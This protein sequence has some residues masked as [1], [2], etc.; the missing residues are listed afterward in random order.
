MKLLPAHLRASVL[1]AIAALTI[2]A[3]GDASPAIRLNQI[4]FLPDTVKRAV[5]ASDSTVPL[6][7][8]VLDEHGKTVAEGQTTVVGADRA[9]GD[10]VHLVRFDQVTKPGTYRI[11]ISDQTS[12]AF[13]VRTGL[14][15]PLASAALNFFYQNRAGIPI[16]A[17]YAGGAQWARP[18]GHP[19]EIATCFRGTDERGTV[20][21]GCSYTLDVTGGWYDAGDQG[22]YVVNG[23]ISLW[24]LQNL[25]ER[26]AASGRFTF[27]DG[28]ARLPEAGNRINDLLDEARWEMRFLLAMQIPDG[29]RAE[30]PVG[31]LPSTGPLT[32]RTI[33]AGGMAHQKVADRNWTPLPTP[34]HNDKEDRLLYP[35][36]TGATLNL[37]AVAAQCARIWRRVDPTFSATCLAAAK[38]AYRAA[39]RNP[40]VYATNS[41]TGSGGYGDND[42]SDELYWATAELWATTGEAVYGDALAA[43]PA[44]SA[45]VGEP[46]WGNVGALGTITLAT[47]PGIPQADAARARAALVAAADGFL[48]ETERSGYRI[49]YA[50]LDY[51]WGSN[52]SILNRAMILG[53]AHGLTGEARYRVGVVDAMDYM[54][55]RNPLDQSYVSGFGARPLLNPH[56]RFWAHQL[57]PSLPG[58]PPG[59]VSGGP[60]STS[61]SD[62]IALTMKG[63]CAPQRCW[64]D[65]ISAYALNEVAINWNAPLLWVAA[66]LDGGA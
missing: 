8:R 47:A 5:V 49:P 11:R 2:G 12:R 14:Y 3:A 54:L 43:M 15:A 61:M 33:D 18:A 41:F 19:R 9:S 57:D 55:G 40:E 63:K 26:Q 37:A 46:N 45:S 25:Y 66:Y 39:L 20:W 27:A 22:K 24:T 59:V 17:R 38:R 34:P 52:S 48:A 44:Q 32:L 53:V 65:D 58:P 13:A 10:N 42:L 60:N 64:K 6:R 23:G 29:V 1:P 28:R 30:V 7:W 56:H 62:P 50:T 21:S 35:P 31:P 51:P 4:G 36:T 16:E